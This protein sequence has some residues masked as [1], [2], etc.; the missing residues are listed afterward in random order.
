MGNSTD[1]P[2]NQP[3]GVTAKEPGQEAR[4]WFLTGLVQGV[5][6]RPFVYRLA[7]QHGLVGWVQNRLGDVEI[8]AQGTADE[9]AAFHKDLVALAPPLAAPRFSHISSEALG[10][11]DGFAILPSDAK[12]QAKVHVPADGFTCEDC[13]Q[14]LND[15][16]DRRYR[17]PFI[18]CTQCGPRYTLINVL[19]YDRANTTMS[20]FPLCGACRAEYE[21]SG[22]RRF[23]AEP[24][25]CPDCGPKLEFHTPG[26]VEVGDT[27]H[28][29]KQSVNFLKAGRIVAVKGIGGYHLLCDAHNDTAVQQLRRTK[30]RPHKPL[31]VM[32]PA[33]IYDE[34]SIAG[35]EVT[36]SDV[37]AGLLK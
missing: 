15:P 8:V 29:L 2:A 27:E 35:E 10:A 37:E 31:A 22:D 25:A 26:G 30:P 12:G 1:I 3:P 24:V 32:F 14:E 6:F 4:H 7:I 18:N 36:L 19:P 5:G 20:G 16:N 13:L 34:L 33:P 28:A 9:L 17:Y 23:H 21:N 11:Y